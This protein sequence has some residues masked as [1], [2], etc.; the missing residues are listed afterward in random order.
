VAEENRLFANLILPQFS[1]EALHPVAAAT[2]I[3]VVMRLIDVEGWETNYY[4]IINKILEYKIV[5]LKTFESN[6]EY[7]F[8][9]HILSLCIFFSNTCTNCFFF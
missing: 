5:M 6:Y 1:F 2:N 4:G 7:C 3:R 8:C 9:S